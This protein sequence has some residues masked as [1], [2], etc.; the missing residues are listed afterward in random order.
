MVILCS[1]TGN[2]RLLCLEL[3]LYIWHTIN[4]WQIYKCTVYS[5]FSALAIFVLKSTFAHQSI[6]LVQIYF[7]S[8]N[9]LTECFRV[10]HSTKRSSAIFQFITMDVQ[11]TCI[12][13]TVNYSVKTHYLLSFCRCAE[14]TVS[15]TH[16]ERERVLNTM[17]NWCAT[18]KLYYFLPV[19]ITASIWNSAAFE[20]NQKILPVS[21]VVGRTNAQI[22]LAGAY[23]HPLSSLFWF[24][25]IS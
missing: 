23:Y 6:R 16:K 25:Q 22:S 13:H 18:C 19:K 17:Q 10:S 24:Q 20:N 4:I 7:Y 1:Q 8:P 5:V 21:P 12:W 9:T 11:H 15:L 3:H 14:S 2:L